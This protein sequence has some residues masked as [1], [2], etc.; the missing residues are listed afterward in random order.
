MTAAGTDARRPRILIGAPRDVIRLLTGALTDGVDVFGAQTHEEAI[1]V[2][3][4]ENPDLI[5]VCYAFDEMR[6]F[7]FLR[8]V[9][10]NW[11]RLHVPTMLVRALPVALSRTQEHEIGESYKTLGVD[12]F[13]NLHAQRQRHGRDGGLQRFRE[14]VLHQLPAMHMARDRRANSR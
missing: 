8:H 13:F 4:A 2:L 1:S 14:S 7:R 5:I 3:H 12:E 6:P 10:E 9:R 11:Q